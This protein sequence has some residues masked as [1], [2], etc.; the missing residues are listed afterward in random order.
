MKKRI[1]DN[2]FLYLGVLELSILSAFL[3]VALVSKI[4][5]TVVE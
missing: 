4:F 1:A 3:V 2:W 5:H